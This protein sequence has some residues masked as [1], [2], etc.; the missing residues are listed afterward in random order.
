MNRFGDALISIDFHHTIIEV[1]MYIYI[2]T[3][4]HVFYKTFANNPNGFYMY[5]FAW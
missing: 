1:C 2:P 3:I 5:Y 4:T